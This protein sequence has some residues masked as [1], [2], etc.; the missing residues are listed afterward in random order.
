MFWSRILRF[1][2]GLGGEVKPDALIEGVEMPHTEVKGWRWPNFTP[3]EIACKGTGLVLIN[4]HSLDCL[5]K[6][7]SKLGVPMI[8]NSAYRSEAHN[9]AV[10]G[11]KNSQHRFGKAFDIRL[12]EDVKREALKLWAKQC[13]FTGI[14]DYPSFVHI[15][16][17]DAPAYWDER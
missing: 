14:G 15:D 11:A 4:A 2:R 7:R 12:T 9:R 13:G 8:I 10:G 16:T 3:R 5:Q 17:R 1:F 6:L